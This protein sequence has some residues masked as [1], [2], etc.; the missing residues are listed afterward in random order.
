MDN[1]ARRVYQLTAVLDIV[2]T[3]NKSFIFATLLR[4]VCSLE[5]FSIFKSLELLVTINRLE[6]P[7]NHSNVQQGHES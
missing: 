4:S 1:I 3:F 6:Y 2:T 5:D 7:N